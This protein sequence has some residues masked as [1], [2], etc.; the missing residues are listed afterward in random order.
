[1]KKK[2]A[3][4]SGKKT[5]SRKDSIQEKEVDDV[6][7]ALHFLSSSNDENGEEVQEIL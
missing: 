1:L 3:V 5:R 4:S 7:A 2:C 6:F